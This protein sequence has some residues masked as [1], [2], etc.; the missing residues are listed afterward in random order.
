MVDIL[1][2]QQVLLNLLRNSIEAIGG[3]GM[4]DGSILIEAK[5]SGAEFLEVIVADSGPGFPPERIESAILPLSSNKP[6]GLGI[7]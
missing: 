6:E 7:G 4:V 3:S 2:I 5:L 1:Q